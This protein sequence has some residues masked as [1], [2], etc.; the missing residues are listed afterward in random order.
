MTEVWPYDPPVVSESLMKC[1]S[2]E[3]LECVE[4]AVQSVQLEA[5]FL[6]PL[7]LV[8]SL[9]MREHDIRSGNNRGVQDCAGKGLCCCFNLRAGY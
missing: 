9:E 1:D 7:L 4:R 5:V 6:L 2:M 8:A 3:A